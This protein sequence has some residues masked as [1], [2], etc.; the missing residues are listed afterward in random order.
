MKRIA[1]AAVV[2]ASIACGGP[3]AGQ[4]TIALSCGA[5]GIEYEVCRTGAE[6]WAQQ[7]GNRVQMV[8][9]PNSSSERLALYQQLLAAHS[10]DIDVFQIDVVWPGILANHLIDLSKNFD[11]ETVGQHFE[12]IVKNDMV[13]GRLVAIPW[14]T[15]AGLLFYRKDLL[16]K[17]GRPVPETWAD[18]T[19]TARTIMKGEREAGRGNM[20][21]FV[22]QG[23]AYEGLTVNALEWVVSFNGGTIVDLDGKITINNP[24]AVEAIDTAASWVNDITPQGVLNYSEEEAR[25]V[26][27]SG[28]AVFMRNW[29]YAWQLVNAPDSAIKDQVAVAVLPKGGADGKHTGGLGGWQLAVSKYSAHANEAID[30]VRYLT[31]REEQKRRAIA[32]GFKPTIPALYDD[33]EVLA[34]SPFM[35]ELYQTFLDAAARPSGVTGVRYNQVSAEFWN[36]VH[37]VLS[38]QDEAKTAMAQLERTLDRVSRGGRW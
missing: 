10:G 26:F 6:A 8:S 23:R 9:T 2:A 21:G 16:E 37:S 36:S 38:G 15:D 34:A 4:T 27:Q 13:D 20:W 7:T 24:R 18:L 11:T 35:K 3:A 14:F 29:P 17:Y 12:A 32:G 30:L 31:G 19:E 5:V 25:G 22:W 33:P 1:A 28:N